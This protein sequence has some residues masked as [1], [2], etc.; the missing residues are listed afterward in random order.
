MF[1]VAFGA[2]VQNCSV[3]RGSFFSNQKIN[4][5]IHTRVKFCIHS[6][7]L[8]VEEF[9]IVFFDPVYLDKILTCFGDSWPD[10]PH[11]LEQETTTTNLTPAAISVY[12]YRQ[13][14]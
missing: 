12:K 3:K 8:T 6:I 4:L 5:D 1:S 11:F 14:F 9:L 10:E 7:N 13:V 2:S